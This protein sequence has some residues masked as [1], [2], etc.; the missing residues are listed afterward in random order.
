MSSPA[1]QVSAR[2]RPQGTV[3]QAHSVGV[4]RVAAAGLVGGEEDLDSLQCGDANVLTDIGVI[5]P[6]C[7]TAWCLILGLDSSVIIC[8]KNITEGGNRQNTV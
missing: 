1:F 5:Y 6:N 2:M 7:Y 4:G 3:D 8:L